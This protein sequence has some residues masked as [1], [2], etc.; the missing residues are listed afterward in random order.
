M[1]FLNSRFFH[2]IQHKNLYH[3]YEPEQ[4]DLFKYSPS[5]ALLFGVFAYLPDPVG[6]LIW[7]ILNVGC[8][9]VALVQ[10]P[11]LPDRARV[12]MLFFD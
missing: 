1:L 9:I 8:L 11:R 6:L 5:F 2:L 12:I 4:W 3:W 7:N 10:V